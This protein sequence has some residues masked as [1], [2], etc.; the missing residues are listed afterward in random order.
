[1]R[2]LF[3]VHNLPDRGSY[4]RALEIARRLSRRGH[5]VQFAYVG[6]RRKYKPS[7]YREGDLSVE[8]A[9]PAG[10]SPFAQPRSNVQ[11]TDSGHGLIMAEMPYFTLFNDRQEGWSIFDNA[12]RVRDAVLEKWD[13]VYGFSHKPDCILPGIAAK[14]RGA[15]FVLDWADLWGGSEGLYRQCV[16][17]SNAFQS[18]PRPLRLARRLVFAMEEIWEPVVYG[19]ADAVTLISEEFLQ[20]KWG[21]HDLAHKSLV[22]HSGAPLEEIRPLDKTTA[23][24]SIGLDLPTGAVLLGY[25]ANFHMDERLLM[26]AFAKVCR[27]RPDVY[28]LVVG[29]DLEATTPEIHEITHD[30]IRHFGRQAFERI[31]QFLGASD[32]L[33]LPLTDIALDRARY[34]H[35]LSDYVASGRPIVACEV[36]ETGRILRRYGVGLLAEPNAESFAKAIIHQVGRPHEWRALGAATRDAAEQHFNWNQVCEKLF[37]FL[38]RHTGLEF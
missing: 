7:Y 15:K 26:E 19:W 18:M 27:S 21:P 34:P 29:A 23:R 8:R 38:S 9:A 35:K 33:L 32:I 17:P 37:A 20:H 31:A 16:I 28:L 3:L 6:N 36:G 13:L 24:Q 2:A 10:D 22:F 12:V 14:A 1:M 11:R 5:F 30:R 4:F 25:V